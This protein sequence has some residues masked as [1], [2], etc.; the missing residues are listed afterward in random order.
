M[1][2]IQQLLNKPIKEMKGGE[3]LSLINAASTVHVLPERTSRKISLQEAEKLTG[4]HP[5][6]IKRYLWD[7]LMINYDE[8]GIV[9]NILV[10]EMELWNA[11]KAQR[12]TVLKDKLRQEIKV[13]RENLQLPPFTK[14]AA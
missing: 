11:V 5:V 4:K 7:G 10:D 14:R 2:N 1:E 13:K 9:P 8:S 12:D 3:L 6:S